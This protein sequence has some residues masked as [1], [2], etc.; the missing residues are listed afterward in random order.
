[1]KQKPLFSVKPKFIPKVV[2]MQALFYGF[3][4]ALALTV[5]GGLMLALLTM[6]LG[7]LG[8]VSIGNIFW[9]CFLLGIIGIPLLYYEIRRKNA[10][11]TRFDF[12]EDRL[13]F[14]YFSGRFL[15]RKQGRLYYTDIVDVVQNT[16]F[17]QGLGDLKTIELH[18]PA[19]AYYEP[20]QKFVGIAIED[21]PISTD[22]GDKILTVLD[23][24]QAEYREAW[25]ADMHRAAIAEMQSAEQIAEEAVPEEPAEEAAAPDE[26]EAAEEAE[27]DM[28]SLLRAKPVIPPSSVETRKTT[29][30]ETPEEEA[31]EEPALEPSIS[32]ERPSQHGQ[33]T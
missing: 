17:L 6:M 32:D 21:V 33:E 10:A 15:N 31:E 13:N 16:S 9:G 4:G 27:S 29:L 8:K 7:F 19:S 11:A 3:L 23:R 18:A 22:V 20:G 28:D 25:A 26:A 2:M 5:V 14:S 12:M 1:M 24:V 30:Q